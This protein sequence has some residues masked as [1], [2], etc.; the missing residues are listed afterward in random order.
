MTAL[1]E[2]MERELG[3]VDEADRCCGPGSGW[4]GWGALRRVRPGRAGALPG[5]V[6]SRAGENADQVLKETPYVLLGQALDD[7]GRSASSRPRPASGPRSCAGRPCTVRLARARRARPG[8]DLA[9]HLDRL[10]GAVDRSLGASTDRADQ[11]AT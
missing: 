4:P 10:L 9:D 3:G 2:A 6:R 11:A 1:G 5:R 7:L 8:A